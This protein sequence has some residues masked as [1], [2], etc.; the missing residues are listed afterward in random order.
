M[1]N[2][3]KSSGEVRDARGRPIHD[4]RVSVIDRCNLRCTYCMPA[5]T[6][7]DRYRFLDESE[8]L[9]FDEIERVV[10]AFVGLG[11]SKVRITG[12][13]PL[14]RPGVADLVARL[15]PIA[16]IDDLA[17]TTNGLLLPRYAQ[18]LRAAGLHRLTVSLDSVDDDV[19]GAMNGRGRGAADVM[20][21]IDAAIAAGFER[22]KINAVVRRG[23]NDDGVLALVERFRGTGHVLR[24]IEY[25]DV[26]NRNGWRPDDVVPSR[27]LLERIDDRYPLTPLEEQYRGEVASRYA[28][29][30]G[31]GELGFIS[32]VSEPF[33]GDCS[34]AR[35]SAEGAVFTCLFAQSGTDLRALLRGGADDDE[36][37]AFLA[38]LWSR[39]A[40]RYSELRAEG[41]AQS[42][43]KV[44]MYH[45][46]G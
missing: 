24:F 44:E 23:V 33:C 39:R 31:A 41:L 14:L 12:G 30:D 6:Y 20:A 35:L 34:R 21:G 36:V 1:V 2:I 38:G 10:R 11:V 25:M 18:A 37:A 46:G 15:A 16:A 32:S 3:S 28:F 27:E 45:I 29:A 42:S 7:H 43:T 22:I 26:G 4:L 9:T 8:W 17:L 40:D 13:E 5:A 19:N